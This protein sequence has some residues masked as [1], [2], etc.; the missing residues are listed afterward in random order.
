[1]PEE[2]FFVAPQ[3]SAT[4]GCL[5][6]PTALLKCTFPRRTSGKLCFEIQSSNVKGTNGA[7]FGIREPTRRVLTGSTLRAAIV[8]LPYLDLTKLRG[9]KRSIYKLLI[10]WC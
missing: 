7:P 3:T 9:G 8:G 5:T 1:M 6:R 2:P 4:N 10:C